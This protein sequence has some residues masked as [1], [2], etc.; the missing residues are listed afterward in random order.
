MAHPE[1]KN[2]N[3]GLLGTAASPDSTCPPSTSGERVMREGDVFRFHYSAQSWERA[4]HGFGDLN[5]CFDGQLFYERGM[6]HDTYWGFR[7]H[8]DSGRRFT[9]A[10]AEAQGTLT[11]VCNLNDVRDVPEH[12]W[13]QYDEADRFDLR[14][15]NGCY[16]RFVVKK[17][18]NRSVEVRLQ[19]LRE[20]VAAA[21]RA[22]ESAQRNAYFI[23]ERCT[24]QR[25]RLEAGEDVLI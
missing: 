4:K 2:Q 3:Q 12:Q 18:A 25:L 5:W 14:H 9:P 7:V 21:Q 1:E 16:K 19:V 10:E 22:V 8:N 15:Q 6:L 13:I 11:F 24:E 17:G 20:R 23:V